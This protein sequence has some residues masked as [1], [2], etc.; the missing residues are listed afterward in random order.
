M[1]IEAR[2]RREWDV[3]KRRVLTPGGVGVNVSV[4]NAVTSHA[5]TFTKA[6]ANATFAAIVVPSWSTTVYVPVA[7]KSTT[8]FTVRFGSASGAADSIS[9]QIVRSE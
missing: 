7:D 8:G 4:G 9:Y 3:I 1:S 2:E 6:E 5:V